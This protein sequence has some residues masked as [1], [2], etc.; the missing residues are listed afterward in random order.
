MQN[1]SKCSDNRHTRTLQSKSVCSRCIWK[2]IAILFVIIRSK[3]VYSAFWIGCYQ[4]TLNMY[5]TDA[6]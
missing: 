4:S 5:T 6:L 2:T 3:C 1:A